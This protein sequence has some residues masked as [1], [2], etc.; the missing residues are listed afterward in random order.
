MPGFSIFSKHIHFLA[1][2]EKENINSTSFY[3]S[4]I[5]FFQKVKID[6]NELLHG[7]WNPCIVAKCSRLFPEVVRVGP[8]YPNTVQWAL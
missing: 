3:E 2:L 4:A 7:P 1:Q 8:G 5:N 6:E